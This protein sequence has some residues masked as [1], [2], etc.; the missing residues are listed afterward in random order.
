MRHPI[1]LALDLLALGSALWLPT[2]WTAAGFLMMVVTGDIRAR[3][4]EK[5]LIAAFGDSYRRY[6]AGVRRFIPGLY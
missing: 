5:L 4:E 6:R 1:Y 3:G 2:A